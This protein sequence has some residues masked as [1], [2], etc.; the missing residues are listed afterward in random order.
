MIGKTLLVTGASGFTGTHLMAAARNAGYHCVALCHHSKERVTAAHQH[1]TANLLQP[2]AISRALKLVKPDKIVHLAAIAFVEYGNTAEIYQT[3]LIGTVNLLNAI[4]SNTPALEKLLIASSANI[5][6]NSRTLPITESTPPNP[7]N[8]YGVSKLAMEQAAKLYQQLPI[9]MA[10]PFN[11]TGQG[12]SLNFLIPKIVDAFKKQERQIMLGNLHVSRDFS[13]VR[14]VIKAYLR[15]LGTSSSPGN[16]NICTGKAVS[17]RYILDTM[18]KI[19]GHEINIKSDQNLVRGNDIE[20]LYG[21]P[22]KLENTIGRYRDH[23][24]EDTLHWMYEHD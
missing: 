14:D 3:N 23:S 4:E 24:I 12:Q 1:V 17:I 15:L 19:S 9:V 20:V 2:E 10:R 18:S 11:Y 21:S 13:D 6:G 16:Y 22:R 8:H 7:V 5:Y